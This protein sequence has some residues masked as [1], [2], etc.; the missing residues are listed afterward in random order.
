M[1]TDGSRNACSFL[2]G[3][4]W[5][6]AKAMGY[7]RI[8]TYIMPEEGGASLRASGWQLDGHSKGLPWQGR[9]GKTFTTHNHHPLGAKER[10]V[11][12]AHD[13]ELVRDSYER[14]R[15][16]KPAQLPQLALFLDGSDKQGQT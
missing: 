15:L 1:A 12:V 5:R 16:E 3:A 14:V 2:Y 8:V 10:W 9:E 6:A 7:R 13:Y 11:A 4:A